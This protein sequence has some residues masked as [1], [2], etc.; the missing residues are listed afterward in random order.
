MSERRLTRGEWKADLSMRF[1]G[2]CKGREAW[3]TPERFDAAKEK[4]SYHQSLANVDRSLVA[5]LKKM[6]RG[7]RVIS[8]AF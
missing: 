2:Y 7:K 6:M 3:M 4:L 1:W 5:K 8:S